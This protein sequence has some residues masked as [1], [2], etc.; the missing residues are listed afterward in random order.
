MNSYAKAI[1][2][3]RAG[4]GRPIFEIVEVCGPEPA[5]GEMFSTN[6]YK[7]QMAVIEFIDWFG[8]GNS[9]NVELFDKLPHKA[10]ADLEN[11]RKLLK[12]CT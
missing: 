4:S 6:N 8:S 7:L 2:F 3:G 1:Y 10:K 12:E 9:V 5:T 11:L